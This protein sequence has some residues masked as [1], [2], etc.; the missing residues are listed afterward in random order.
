MGE[1]PIPTTF[2]ESA[3]D[4]DTFVSMIYSDDAITEKYMAWVLEQ[5]HITFKNGLF[6]YMCGIPSRCHWRV[7]GL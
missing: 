7:W 1:G 6:S 4:P 5:M 2:V 3:L